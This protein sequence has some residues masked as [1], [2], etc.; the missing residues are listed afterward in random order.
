MVRLAVI[1]LI[2]AAADQA[3]KAWMLHLL[4]PGP[5]S[6]IQ[7]HARLILVY[8]TGA[9]FGSFAGLE[10][11]RWL[12]IAATL[13]ALGLAVWV[14]AGRLGA[15]RGM[16]WA[17]GLICGGALGNLVDRVRLGKVLD[18]V[19]LYWGAWHWPAFNLADAAITLGGL[20]VAFLLLRGKT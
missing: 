16:L 20:Y 19:D 7:D 13:T 18:F 2:L 5:V 9:A 11:S 6:L 12:L 8:N 14:A 4:T 17:L 15:A 10:G 1:A 3:L